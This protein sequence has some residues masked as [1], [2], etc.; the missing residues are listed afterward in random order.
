MCAVNDALQNW[1]VTPFN[2]SGETAK[3][4]MIG[5]R[6][7]NESSSKYLDNRRKNFGGWTLY[8]VDCFDS[9]YQQWDIDKAS[10]AAVFGPIGA[11]K[12]MTW[13]NL[14]QRAD[15][16]VHVGYEGRATRT[17]ATPGPASSCRCC[18]S[19]RTAGPRRWACRPRPAPTPGAAVS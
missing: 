9:P 18:A 14:E 6:P 1:Q 10:Y 7:K 16:L 15:D 19:R 8:M 17:T 2:A 11:H 4:D 12:G 5:V 3:W 13:A